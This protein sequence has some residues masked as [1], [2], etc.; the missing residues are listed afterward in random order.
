MTPGSVAA[1]NWFNF[2]KRWKYFVKSP[3]IVSLK[4][5]SDHFLPD[6]SNPDLTSPQKKQVKAV[7]TSGLK[8]P[9]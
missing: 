5:S 1:M 2:R 3:A 7:I 8:T 9:K 4:A 6:T